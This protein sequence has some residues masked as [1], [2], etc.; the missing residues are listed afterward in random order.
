[1][2][3]TPRFIEVCGQ[4]PRQTAPGL[5]LSR[6]RILALILDEWYA[7]YGVHTNKQFLYGVAARKYSLT[8]EDARRAVD[9]A[10]KRYSESQRK[11][12]QAQPPRASTPASIPPSVDYCPLCGAS[13]TPP[14]YRKPST[15]SSSSSETNSEQKPADESSSPCRDT[16][17]TQRR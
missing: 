10:E 3:E 17:R 5:L 2:S 13:M 4:H 8:S 7:K 16:S 12:E 1:M 11:P 15:A 9:H 14:T 6:D